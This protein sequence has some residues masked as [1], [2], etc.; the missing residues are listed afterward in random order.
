MVWQKFSSS[1]FGRLL[2]LCDLSPHVVQDEP[3]SRFLVNKRHYAATKGRVKPEAMMPL[4]NVA[5]N[6]FETS[7]HRTRNLL[8]QQ[9]WGIGYRYVEKEVQH[10]RIR[11]RGHCEARVVLT[12]ELAFEVNGRPYPRHVDIV[13]WPDD[14]HEQLMKATEIADV[15]RL[16]LDPRPQGSKG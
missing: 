11:G 1:R 4:Q 10:R 16:E 14:E 12:Q 13:K 2:G 3:I 9:I 7:T 5:R 8:P 6:R 15:M